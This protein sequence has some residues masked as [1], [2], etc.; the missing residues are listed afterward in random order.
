MYPGTTG[1]AVALL[2]LAAAAATAQQ[3]AQIPIHKVTMLA[4][5]DSGV[6]ANVYMIHVRPDGNVLLNDG[7]MHR[8]LLFDAT[9]K[10]YRILAD[11]AGAAPSFGAGT[12][13]LL[14]FPGDSTA[15]VD[16]VSQGLVIIDAAGTFG[17]VVAPPVVA[18]MIFFGSSAYGVPGFDARGRLHYRGQLRPSAT[19]P[20]KSD[21]VYTLP[22]SAPVISANFEDRKLDTV[23]MMRVPKR[24]LMYHNVTSGGSSFYFSSEIINPLPVTDEWAYFPDGTVAIVRGHDYHIDWFLADGSR[25]STPKMPFDWRRLTDADK[26]R[27]V[28]SVQHA[29]DSAYDASAARLAEQNRT[30]GRSGTTG[31]QA[32]KATIIKPTELPDYYPPVRSSSQMRVDLD[33]NLWI[34]PTTSLQAKGGT[35]FDVVNR[36]G[37][38]IERV[39]F[40]EGRNLHGFGPGGIV[41]MSVPVQY[42]WP[43]LERGRIE[44]G[45]TGR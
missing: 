24:Q 31:M 19:G 37:E 25:K 35:L 40:P 15:F 1:R 45:V 7:N 41:Y 16:R 44:R 13:G 8:L 9:L 36:N 14:P 22:D 12:G 21:T 11:T 3:P 17:R 10:T 32:P 18:D 2:A 33:G 23:V 26:V 6:I 20:T 38:I 42:G 30:A 27:M 29:L 39:Q 28:D 34:M 43:R 4:S 5:T